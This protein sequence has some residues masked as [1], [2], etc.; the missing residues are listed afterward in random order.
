MLIGAFKSQISFSMVPPDLNPLKDMIIDNWNNVAFESDIWLWLL[1]SIILGVFVA[2]INVFV[3]ACAGY[4]FAKKDFIGKTVLFGIIIATMILP[5]QML[6]IPNYLVAQNLHLVNKTIGVILTTVSL[7]F[8]IFLC[9]QFI[10]GIPTEL[11]EAAEIDGCH[12]VNKFIRIILPLSTPALG[13]LA[14]FSFLGSWNDYLW[15]LIMLSDTKKYTITIGISTLSQISQ[16]NTGRK[17]MAALIATVP[18][19]I[20][21]LSF[22][23]VFIK[24]I[25]M[26]G[27]KG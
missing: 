2:S 1:N 23:K 14:I 21:F 20:I 13:A 11:I 9:R 8:G 25:T 15:Q 17:M 24:G 18:I 22:Q 7:P 4:A 12:E 10:V 26:G 6:L 3:A 5:R 16:S 27:V 19:L